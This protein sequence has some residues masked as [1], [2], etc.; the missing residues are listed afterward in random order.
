[1]REELWK[2]LALEQNEADES[3]QSDAEVLGVPPPRL[4]VTK[5]GL[6]QNID[7]CAICW[8]ARHKTAIV[9]LTAVHMEISIKRSVETNMVLA[10]RTELYR[11][12]DW[13]LSAHG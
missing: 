9:Q 3:D 11:K 2:R 1:M 10:R 8:A 5:H 4:R 6:C 7:W 13:E 12:E